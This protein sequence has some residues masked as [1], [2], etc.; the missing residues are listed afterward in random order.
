[1]GLVEIVIGIATVG[2]D[3]SPRRES[4]FGLF[5]AER[6]VMTDIGTWMPAMSGMRRG[7]RW[8]CVW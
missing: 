8:V 7:E 6:S 3:K 1:M 5:S 4:L 2:G